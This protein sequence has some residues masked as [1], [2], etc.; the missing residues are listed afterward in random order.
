MSKPATEH[1]K[2]EGI[3]RN[4]REFTIYCR[5]DIYRNQMGVRRTCVLSLLCS[6]H[7]Y[8]SDAWWK[9]EKLVP[10]AYVA[11]GRRSHSTFW[12]VKFNTCVCL[13]HSQPKPLPSEQTTWCDC[14]TYN[15]CKCA[16]AGLHKWQTHGHG[17]R[18]FSDVLWAPVVVLLPVVFFGAT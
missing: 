1:R 7:K 15:V 10:A 17:E 16:D 5:I 18:R 12:S 9:N 4:L 14:M 13:L 6:E 2:Q 11:R 8:S 3:R